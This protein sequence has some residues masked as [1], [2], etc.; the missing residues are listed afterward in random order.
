MKRAG[1]TLIELLVVLVIL[2]V[3]AAQAMPA[4]RQHVTRTRRHEAQSALLKLMMQ[5]ERFYS[6]HNTYLAFSSAS[7]ETEAQQFQWWSGGSPQSS[8]YELEGK[9]CDGE[10][11]EQCVQIVAAPGT[12][13]VDHGF[14]D[15]DCDVLT[16]TSTGRRLASGAAAGC[17]P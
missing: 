7:T 13:M 14:H 1:F 11:I 12:A 3:L 8:A 15:E 16:L 6:Q 4:Y 2:A 9:A 5:Q 17:W 10:Q